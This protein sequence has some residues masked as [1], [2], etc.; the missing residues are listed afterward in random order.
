MT[1]PTVS[2]A[3]R[4]ALRNIAA[5]HE[6]CGDP[7][8]LRLL[9]L[10]AGG[11]LCVC[12]LQELTGESQPFVSRHLA[13]LRDA[14]LVQV[15]RRSKFAYYSLTELPTHAQRQLDAILDG[16]HAADARL[17]RERDAAAATAAKRGATP[18]N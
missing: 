1:A 4:A 8:R 2:P 9:N 11:E 16:L 17:R 10:L 13:R 5:L 15:E 6:A 3:T 12:D 7:A 18:C 14:G